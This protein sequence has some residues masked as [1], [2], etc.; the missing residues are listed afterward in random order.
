MT[1][2]KFK[3]YIF[4]TIFIIHAIYLGLIIKDE[5]LNLFTKYEKIE[6]PKNSM[7]DCKIPNTMNEWLKPGESKEN[8]KVNLN[9]AN[10]FNKSIQYSLIIG[11]II[12]HLLHNRKYPIK[13]KI[14]K[15]MEKLNY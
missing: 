2:Y 3:G 10:N 4:L 1:E 8:K 14:K 12:N 15:L 13:Q 11:L 6:C 5:G 7:T 9:K